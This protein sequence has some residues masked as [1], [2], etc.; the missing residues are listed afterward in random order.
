MRL[1]GKRTGKAIELGDKVTVEIANVSVI[2]RRIDFTLIEGQKHEPRPATLLPM[3]QAP[4]R[5]DSVTPVGR[6]ALSFHWNDGH[7]TGIYSWDYL[8]RHCGCAECKA[9]EQP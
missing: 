4:P 2:R 5:P 6:Y 7:Q 3:Y 1:A 8:R 9:N